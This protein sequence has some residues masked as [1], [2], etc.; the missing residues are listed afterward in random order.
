MGNTWGF[1]FFDGTMVR[2][3]KREK[4]LAFLYLILDLLGSAAAWTLFNIF[5]KKYIESRLFN[6]AIPFIPD[7][8]FLIGLVIIPLFWVTLFGIAGFYHNVLRKS[9]L[10]EFVSSVG[11]T[12]LGC[13]I[14]FFILLLDDYIVSYKSYYAILSGLFILE[15]ALTYPAR[16]ILTTRTVHQ[17][18]NRKIGF[19]TLIIGHSAKIPRLI[20]DLDSETKSQGFLIAGYINLSKEEPLP[21]ISYP[22]LGNL[23]NLTRII[24]E[25]HIEEVILAT[26]GSHTRELQT[27]IGMLLPLEI[28]VWAIPSM[29]DI[30]SGRVK[31]S[32]ILNAPLISISFEL[33]PAW[34]AN[35][36]QL[37]DYLFALTAIT[38][39]SPFFIALPV[40]IKLSSRGPVIFK[41]ERIGQFGKPFNLYKFRSMYADAEKN[42]PAL[43]SKHDP[44]VTPIGRFMRKTRLDELPN[45]INVLKGDMSIVGPRPERQIFIDQ[46]VRIAPHYLH[47][48]KVKPGI[49]S[50]GQV[51]FGYAENVEQMVERLKYDI[52]YLENMTLYVD[53]KIIIYTILTVIKGRGV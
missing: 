36:K 41:Q 30:L 42:G 3:K 11:Y 9:R 12:L 13:L 46:I 27:I 32:G 22:L 7:H 5:R 17:I 24:R 47:L 38:L 15:F 20:G 18:H 35:I 53:L 10:K 4:H 49:T 52:I 40:L 33:M 8:K 14:I 19:P 37:L 26:K 43:S 39:L 2:K 1:C 23:N 45:F 6:T 50:W 51:K 34:Q 31:M 21:N 48:Q 25:H 28:H 29:Y 44:R 16:L